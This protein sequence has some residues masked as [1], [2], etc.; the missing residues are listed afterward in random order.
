MLTDLKIQRLKVEQGKTKRHKD[1]DGLSLEVRASGK[2]VFIFRFQWNKKPQTITLGNYPSLSLAEARNQVLVYRESIDKGIDPRQSD[3]AEND[4]K[5]TFRVIAEQWHQKNNHRWK[6]VTRNRHYKSLARD[7]YPFIGEKSIDD[8]T[9][10]DLLQIIQPHELKGHHEIA[11]RLHDRLQSI[12]EFAVGASLTENYP[13]I[14]LKKA[15]SPKP[16]VTNQPAIRPNEAHEMLE[17]IKNSHAT[18]INKIYIELLAHLFTRPSELRLAQWSEFNLQ[19]AEW[20]IPADRMKMAAAHW[21]PL[22]P[23]VI[24]LLKELRLLT[25]FTPYLF[26]SPTAKKSQPI[27][28]TSARKLLHHTGYK[29]RHTLHG[30][31]ALASTVLHEQSHFRTDAIEAQLAHKVQGVRGV[32]LR[33]DFK[34][35][36]KELMLWYSSWLNINAKA[37][38]EKVQ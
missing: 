11:H 28:E 7:V 10:N 23:H 5:M 15:L 3:E 35:E 34:Q 1:R 29:D 22:S 9:K 32:Y 27:S 17:V 36:R 21:V 20:H 12:F 4:S 16:R 14:G 13:F 31:R 19:Q 26:N 6:E 24:K 37:K 33:A 30:F 2:K 18:K 25:G 8:I 38:L